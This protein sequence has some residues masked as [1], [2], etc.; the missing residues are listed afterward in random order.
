[1][2]GI[3]ILA[4]SVIDLGSETAVLWPHQ[5]INLIFESYCV[6]ESIDKE[7]SYGTAGYGRIRGKLVPSFNLTSSL[8][9]QFGHTFSILVSHQRL[10]R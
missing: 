4:E 6:S 7:V 9:W 10:D 2:P 3:P 5:D 1:M 8:L